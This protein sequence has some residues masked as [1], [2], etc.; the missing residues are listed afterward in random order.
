MHQ[1]PRPPAWTQTKDTRARTRSERKRED[2]VNER[3]AR[4]GH[5]QALFRV[6]NERIDGLNETFAEIGDGQFEVVCECGNIACVE[7]ILMPAAEY[8]HVRSDP[9]LFILA[10]GHEDATVESV[11]QEQ[12]QRTSSSARTPEAQPLSPSKQ[13][14]THR[15]ARAA[16][17]RRSRTRSARPLP[18]RR[19]GTPPYPDPAVRS[20]DGTSASCLPRSGEDRSKSVDDRSAGGTVV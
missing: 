17:A 7:Q 5:N 20:Q 18:G 3:E 4:V 16:N 8:A 19:S 15:P 2:A 10:P 1:I 6:V 13:R 14:P 12:S 11:I 9:T